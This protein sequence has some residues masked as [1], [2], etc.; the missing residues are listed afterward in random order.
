MPYFGGSSRL[1]GDPGFFDV[2]KKVAGFGLSLLPGG[3][4]V[5]TAVRGAAGLIGRGGTPNFVPPRQITGAQAATI[6]SFAGGAAVGAIQARNGAACPVGVKGFHLNKSSYFLMD[7][8]FVAEGTRMVRNRN[9]NPYNKRA[10]TR[11][12][13][14]LK[15][16]GRGMKTIRKSVK[17]AAKEI[18]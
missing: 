9:R 15:S 1:A 10:A 16:L 7:G 14:R 2:F 4:A 3:G 13:S 5:K 8:T 18:G 11:A 6:G 12:A 17:S